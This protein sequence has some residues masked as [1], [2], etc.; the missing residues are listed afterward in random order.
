[1]TTDTQPGSTGFNPDRRQVLLAAGAVT[2]LAACG[3][4]DGGTPGTGPTPDVAA[5][6]VLA[7]AADVPVGGGVILGDP[8]IVVTQPTAGEYRAFS[9]ICTHEQ[10]PVTSVSDNV[11]TCPCHSSQFDAVDGS[12]IGGPAILG[13]APVAVEVD[14]GQIV[15]AR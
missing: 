7:A 6:T 3:G 11:I 9:S 8:D 1:M 10:C 2:L 15:A 12:A 5:G 13:L 4:S 14:G